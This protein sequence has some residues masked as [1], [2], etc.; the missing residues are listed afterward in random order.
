MV[1]ETGINSPLESCTTGTEVGFA[2]ADWA[3]AMVEST[4]RLVEHKTD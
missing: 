2:R 1:V 4:P 3:I